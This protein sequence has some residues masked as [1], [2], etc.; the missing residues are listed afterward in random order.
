MMLLVFNRLK[1][2]SFFLLWNCSPLKY[3]QL[4][5]WAAA[6]TA[7]SLCGA[8]DLEQSWFW[9]IMILGSLQFNKKYLKWSNNKSNTSNIPYSGN[10]IWFT[11]D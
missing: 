9:T 8:T 5:I 4:P 3:I 6:I 2:L 11:F 1:L 7:N 10:D